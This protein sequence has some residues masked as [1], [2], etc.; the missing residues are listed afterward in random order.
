MS[1]GRSVREA[2]GLSRIA[3]ARRRAL[4]AKNFALI[5]TFIAF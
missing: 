3:V 5:A 2:L 4:R 1:V